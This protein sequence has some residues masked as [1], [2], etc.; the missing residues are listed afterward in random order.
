V[1]PTGSDVLDD[2][3]LDEALE[4][5]FDGFSAPEAEIELEHDER[6]EQDMQDES[7]PLSTGAFAAMEGEASEEIETAPVASSDTKPE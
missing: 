3:E 7:S 6:D 4:E 2:D 5:D 1:L